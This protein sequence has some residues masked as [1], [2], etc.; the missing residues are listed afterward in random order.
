MG[1][2]LGLTTQCVKLNVDDNFMMNERGKIN[3]ISSNTFVNN[4]LMKM[5]AKFG[6][7]NARLADVSMPAFLKQKVMILGMDVFHP[8]PGSALKHSL[9]GF[10]ASYTRCFTK[11]FQ[12]AKAQKHPDSEDFRRKEEIGGDILFNV[13]LF[14]FNKW[15][16]VNKCYP[17]Y[18]LVFRFVSF[19][20]IDLS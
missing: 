4:M 3:K 18:V 2:E 16:G 12:Q 6:G 15:K 13:M 11:Y 5:N 9:A 19:L 7:E 20:V 1:N 10:V 14:F 8:G 17:D